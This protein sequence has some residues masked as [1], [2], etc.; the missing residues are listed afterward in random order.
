MIINRSW[1]MPNKYTFSIAPIRE[2]IGK[3]LKDGMVS[4]DPYSGKSVIATHRNDLSKDSP[5]QFHIEA[6]DFLKKMI[7]SEI[8]ADL[9]LIDPPYSPRQIKECYKS[10]GKKTTQEDCQNSRIASERNT[11]IDKLT[12]PGSIVLSFGWNSCGVGVK[13]GFK[14]EE[15][16]LVCHGASHNDTI[17]TMEVKQITT[18]DLF[19]SL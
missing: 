9:I 8:I 1:A 7:E 3:Y 19:E 12:K 4:I 10:I 2:F 5:S 18:M 13:Y 17:C 6:N 15:I 14:I 11:L 16:L